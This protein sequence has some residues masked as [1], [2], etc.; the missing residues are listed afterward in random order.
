MN[1]EKSVNN[2]KD[3][4]PRDQLID[5]LWRHNPGLVQLLGLCPLL[6]I[7]NT[8]INALALGLATMLTLLI[9]N[10]TVSALRHHIATEIR[11]PLFVLLIA[12]TV[13]II[14]LTMNAWFHQLYLVL[15]IFLPLIVTNCMIL[16]RAESFARTHTIGESAIDAFSNG[17]GFLLVLVTLG[18]TRELLGSGT[19]LQDAHL[20]FGDQ[21]KDWTLRMSANP[22]EK[23]SSTGLLLALLPPGAFMILGLMLALRNLLNSSAPTTESEHVRQ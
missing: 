13:T 8:M 9:T 22:L 17:L 23:E 18:A 5:G 4:L 20:L 16:G 21:A 10:T 12:S 3:L 15:G 7:S 6:A 19:L 1:T 11:I 2:A 14:E